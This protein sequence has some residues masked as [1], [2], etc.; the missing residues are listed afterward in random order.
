MN[1]L[2]QT[3]KIGAA[4]STLV[5]GSAAFAQTAPATGIDLTPITSQ[6][7]AGPITT[8]VM[9]VAGTLAGIYVVVRGVRMALSFIRG[10]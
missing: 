6:F 8:A 3:A 10:G 7:T 9:A 1:L 5:A 4:L 2:K